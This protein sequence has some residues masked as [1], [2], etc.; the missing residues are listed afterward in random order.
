MILTLF[1]IEKI[2]LFLFF[3][4]ITAPITARDKLSDKNLARDVVKEFA[5]LALFSLRGFGKHPGH[6]LD[7]PILSL[8]QIL[9]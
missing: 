6:G 8:Y 3:A 4:L 9:D 2:R 1:L 7:A 5:G